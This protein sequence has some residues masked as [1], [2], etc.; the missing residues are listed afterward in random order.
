MCVLVCV[1]VC[2]CVFW[3]LWLCVVCVLGCWCVCVSVWVC[4]CVCW[5]VWVFVD[6]CWCVCFGG[7]GCVLVC[8]CVCVCVFGC[9][10]VCVAWVYSQRHPQRYCFRFYPPTICRRLAL[11][12]NTDVWKKFYAFIVGQPIKFHLHNSPIKRTLIIMMVEVG[13]S[14][15]TSAP[16]YCCIECHTAH[17][18][19]V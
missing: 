18:V 14:P 12:I 3:C 11:R 8:V 7:C 4:W 10:G 15:E 2:S 19:E 6:V 9:V 17:C 5:C 13:N 16:I 1:G